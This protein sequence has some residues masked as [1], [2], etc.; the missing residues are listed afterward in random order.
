MFEWFKKKQKKEERSDRKPLEQHADNIEAS[1]WEIKEIYDL[2]TEEVARVVDLKRKNI[3]F[4][5]K[6][7][8]MVKEEKK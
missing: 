1:L 7:T 3:K 8:K 6:T 5:H 2:P 4:M